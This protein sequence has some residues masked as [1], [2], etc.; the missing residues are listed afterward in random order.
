[1]FLERE[2]RGVGGDVKEVLEEMDPAMKAFLEMEGRL[3][4]AKKVAAAGK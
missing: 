3:K 1:M 4:L 2:K